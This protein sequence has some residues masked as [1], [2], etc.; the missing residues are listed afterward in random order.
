[1]T[2][3][4][5]ASGQASGLDWVWE[6]RAVN[7]RGID[8]RLRLPSGLEGLEREAKAMISA[9]L[10]RGS[11]AA[12]LT[13]STTQ[14]NVTINES[15]LDAYAALSLRL[16]EHYRLPLP[17]AAEL[18]VLRGVMDAPVA[19]DTEP[20]R[21]ARQT[22]L[23]ASLT[24]A[25]DGLRQSRMREGEALAS[26]LSGIVDRIADHAGEADRLAGQQPVLIRARLARRLEELTRGQAGV[27]PDRLAQEVALLAVKAD[28]R[29]ELDRL[30]AHVAQARELLAANGPVGRKLDFLAQEFG[31]EVNTLCSKSVSI[32]LTRI[33]LDLKALVDQFREQVQNVE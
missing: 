17:S 25:L 6:L 2:G 27:D 21:Q 12:A 16:A 1:M 13:F 15:V 5:R 24:L 31:R 7:S 3:F 20:E 11:I 14:N 30:T 33:G 8:V 9:A 19:E 4:G 23:L 22:A 10:E 32:E 18:L 29:E 28:V 26:V